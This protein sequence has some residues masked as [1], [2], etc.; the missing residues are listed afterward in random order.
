MILEVK[1]IP[2][3]RENAV[4]E[5]KE[6]VLKVKIKGAPVKGEVNENLIKF[7]AEIFGVSRGQIRIISGM[8]GPRKRVEVMGLK[9]IP[10]DI[11]RGL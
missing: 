7:F 9:S 1:V 5:F 11:M 8:T 4:V 3:A 6:G 2:R 10:F